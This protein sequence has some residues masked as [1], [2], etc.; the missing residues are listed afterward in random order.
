MPNNWEIYAASA[1][2]NIPALLIWA[3]CNNALKLVLG[4]HLPSLHPH[5]NLLEVDQEQLEFEHRTSGCKT[6]CSTIKPSHLFSTI[7]SFSSPILFN[8]W[9][10]MLTS[11]KLI[12]RLW[13][14]KLKYVSSKIKLIWNLGYLNHQKI[15]MSSN[16]MF[17]F[18]FWSCM[19]YQSAGMF[20]MK[21][22]QPEML[23]TAVTN[24]RGGLLKT[25]FVTDIKII[26]K[27]GSSEWKLS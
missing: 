9:L 19:N 16:P 4:T 18:S 1:A 15:S 6:N 8:Y 2:N 7:F 17:A 14:L 3:A 20:T 27:N 22:E 21:I 26:D 23:K 25:L 11:R 10:V 12:S 13:V 5:S 24:E